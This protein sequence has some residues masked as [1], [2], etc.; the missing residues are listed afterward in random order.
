MSPSSGSS[1]RR[2]KRRRDDVSCEPA[3]T[4]SWTPSA[5]PFVTTLGSCRRISPPWC[6]DRGAVREVG[7]A[8]VRKSELSAAAVAELIGHDGLSHAV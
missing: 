6:G 5:Q 1:T 2:T 8:A 4:S 3:F 7:V